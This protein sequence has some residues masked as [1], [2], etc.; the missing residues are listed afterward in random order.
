MSPKQ[1]ILPLCPRPVISRDDITVPLAS[2][3]APTVMARPLATRKTRRDFVD[4]RRVASAAE[5]ISALTRD[6]ELFGFTKGQFSLLDIL[7][8]MFAK[9]G[10]A[11]MTLSTWT[12]ARAEIAEI[13]AMRDAGT[14]LDARWLVDISM[15]RTDKGILRTISTLF[16]RDSIRV[17]KNHSKFAI[18]RAEGWDLVLWSSMNLNAEQPGSTRR[19][20]P[21]GESDAAAGET[22]PAKTPTE[23]EEDRRIFDLVLSGH[24]NEQILDY[25]K[26]CGHHDPGKIALRAVSRFVT[27]AEGVPVVAQCGF[28]LDSYREL[29]RKCA[30]IG[31]FQ[32]ARAC[33]KE[34]FAT[35]RYLD[36]RGFA[37]R[38]EDEGK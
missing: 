3:G 34:Y 36:E 29:A 38:D 17:T 37:R 4:A 13:A 18:L 19:T 9:T 27:Q 23:E 26:S 20:L 15:M 21:M 33:M 35:V 31:D 11:H 16:G 14:I 7:K 32:G 1:N 22:L 12:A 8:A 24:P 6:N 28:L 25:V 2:L 10:P 30:D 5:A